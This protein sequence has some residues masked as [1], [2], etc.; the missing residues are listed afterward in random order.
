L[1]NPK[2]EEKLKDYLNERQ[3]EMKEME[4]TKENTQRTINTK[5]KVKA[6]SIYFE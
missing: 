1:I 3:M 6:F 5:M 2:V 4:I